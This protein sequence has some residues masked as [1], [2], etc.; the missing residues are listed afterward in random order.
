MIFF[1][2]AFKLVEKGMHSSASQWWIFKRKKKIWQTKE[3]YGV[4]KLS[5]A[6]SH[7]IFTISFSPIF[8]VKTNSS[9]WERVIRRDRATERTRR[10]YEKNNTHSQIHILKIYIYTRISV[11]VPE[12][13]L[14]LNYVLFYSVSV[15]VLR[16]LPFLFHHNN[17]WTDRKV[18]MEIWVN[19]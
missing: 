17:E 14:H 10:N 9:V 5:K 1:K 13:W 19:F 16:D 3:F 15:N 11:M 4:S 18:L 12:Y 6:I 2:L 8:N 7:I